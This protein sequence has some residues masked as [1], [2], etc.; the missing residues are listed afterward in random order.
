MDE[1]RRWL[2]ATP[3][4]VL[5]QQI[6]APVLILFLLVLMSAVGVTYTAYLNRQA[7]HQLQTQLMEKNALQEEWGQLLLQHSTLTSHGRVE[8]I[9]RDQLNMDVPGQSRVLVVQP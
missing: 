2:D 9:A 1:I 4:L 5:R 6:S 8:T 3:L 7:F